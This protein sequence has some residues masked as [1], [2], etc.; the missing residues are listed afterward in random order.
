M[1]LEPNGYIAPHIDNEKSSVA[2]AVN[3][4]LNNPD[5]CRF[6]TE[7]GTIP[8]NDNGSIM[9]INNHYRHSVHNDS[10]TDR[11]HI[12]VHGGWRSPDWQKLVVESYRSKHGG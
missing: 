12:I 7:W 8:F 9:M 10:D 5:G 11:F 4:S 3:I 6:T 2:A 1:L